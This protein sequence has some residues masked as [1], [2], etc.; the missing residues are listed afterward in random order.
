MLIRRL[1]RHNDCPI[2]LSPPCPIL[3]SRQQR[4]FERQSGAAT[5]L[6]TGSRLVSY[7]HHFDSVGGLIRLAP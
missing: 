5:A 2:L 3:L 1:L 7:D 6:E 4:F